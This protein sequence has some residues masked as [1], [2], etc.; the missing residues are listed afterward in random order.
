M[1]RAS[2]AEPLAANAKGDHCDME[3]HSGVEARLSL[4]WS[5]TGLSYTLKVVYTLL[6]LFINV[7]ARLMP[8]GE[9]AP[10]SMGG[11]WLHHLTPLLASVEFPQEPICGWSHSA[12][13][14]VMIMCRC[15][16]GMCPCQMCLV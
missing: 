13:L 8:S 4:Q 10:E 1:S 15:I 9:F 7:L 6:D 3:Q 11:T 5:G 2:W 16:L 14:A 12:D